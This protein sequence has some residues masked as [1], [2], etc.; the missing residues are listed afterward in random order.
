M[1]EAE[2][3]AAAELGNQQEPNTPQNVLASGL[4]MARGLYSPDREAAA[5]IKRLDH[6]GYQITR[7]PQA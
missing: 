3:I 2:R 6:F 5:L 1:T 4:I 7:K